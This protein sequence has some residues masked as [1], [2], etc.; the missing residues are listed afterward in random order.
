MITLLQLKYFRQ[1]AATEHIT[2][3]ARELYISQTALSSMIIGLE[4]ELGT[5]LFERSNRAIHLNEAGRL[6]LKYVDEVFL[7]LENGRMALNDI[8]ESK[9]R[10]ISIAMG[11]SLVWVPMIHTFHQKFPQ[12]NISQFNM[13]TTALTASLNDFSVD[14]VIAGVGDIP[15]AELSYE[16]IKTDGIYLC[17]P[18]GH[19]LADRECVYMDE[20]CDEDFINLQ[21]G[22]P[23]R[24]YCDYLFEQAGY[25]VHSVLECD[26]TM[27]AAL[28]ESG[29]GVSLTSASAREVD[30]LKPNR[31]IRIAD[32]YARREMAIFWNPRKYISKAMTDFKQYCISYYV[33]G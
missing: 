19:R 26:Y 28:I 24:R 1:L 32:P 21:V 15:M 4:K 25:E 11:S 12:Y 23:W 30:L 13:S 8:T 18:K 2:R 16:P 7:A 14:F 17:V 27:R 9:E 33:A 20:L 3:T 5:P 31:Y 22:S 10:K 6:Y 29:F